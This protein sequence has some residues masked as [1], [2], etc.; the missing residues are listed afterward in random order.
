MPDDCVFCK[1]VRG[2]I[3]SHKVYENELVLAILDINPIAP[4]HALVMPKPHRET[5][6]DLPPDL[7]GELVVRAQQVARGLVRAT[8]ALGFNLLMNNHKC[9]G[10]AIPH[11]HWHIIPRKQDDGVRFNWT[12]RKYGEGEAESTAASIREALK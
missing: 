2:E 8:G 4:G 3:S 5:F 12:P 7:L 6:S 10:Q 11:A 9:S 1:I